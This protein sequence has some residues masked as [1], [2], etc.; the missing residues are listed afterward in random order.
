M[1]LCEKCNENT[2]HIDTDS[3]EKCMNCAEAS[4]GKDG[5]ATSPKEIMEFFVVLITGLAIS[6]MVY[7]L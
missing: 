7:A 5:N 6:V 2:M 1:A 4:I 3:G